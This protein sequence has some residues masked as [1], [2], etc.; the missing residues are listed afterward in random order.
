MYDSLSETLCMLL[1]LFR[2]SECLR[3]FKVGILT[4]F[5]EEN[6]ENYFSSDNIF[7]GIARTHKNFLYNDGDISQEHHDIFLRNCS[8]FHKISLLYAWITF[9]NILAF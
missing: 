1:H 8:N 4:K 7:I 6:S 2:Q 9:L 5:D 3:H